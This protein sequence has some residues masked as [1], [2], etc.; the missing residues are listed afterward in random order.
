M[1]T[2]WFSSAFGDIVFAGHMVNHLLSAMLALGAYIIG[3][4]T[5][6]RAVAVSAAFLTAWSPELFNNQLLFG[7]DPT[8]QFS[9]I[10]LATCSVVAMSRAH[11][12][13]VVV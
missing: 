8:L 12:A 13:W 9:V 6:G 2:A 3:R 7:V 10:L 11:W 1:L 4:V 5:S